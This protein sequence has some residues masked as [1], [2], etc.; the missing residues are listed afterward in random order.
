MFLLKRVICF[1]GG[2]FFLKKKNLI[3]RK[4][5]SIAGVLYYN[6]TRGSDEGNKEG[7][8]EP[9]KTGAKGP[10]VRLV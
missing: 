8:K 3:G 5:T 2:S 10:R 9:L 6:S 4:A 7:K 1:F